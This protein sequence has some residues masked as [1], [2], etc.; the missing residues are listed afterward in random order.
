MNKTSW[1]PTRKWFALVGTGLASIVAN[2]ILSD[3]VFDDV[4]K[5]MLATLVVAAAGAYFKSNDATPTGD[6]VPPAQ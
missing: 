3:F 4:E 2:L 1:K 6:G 5:G